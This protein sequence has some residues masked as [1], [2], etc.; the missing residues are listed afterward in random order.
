VALNTFERLAELLFAPGDELFDRILFLP[1]NHDHHAWEMGRETHYRRAVAAHHSEHGDLPAPDHVTG[2]DPRDAVPSLL[3]ETVVG[4][5]DQAHGVGESAASGDPANPATSANPE[6]SATPA[7]PV[8]SATSANP[9][10]PAE[11]PTR[12][13]KGEAIAGL[14]DQ[15]PILGVNTSADE[16]NRLAVKSEAVLL[17]H[18]D[19]TPGTGDMRLVINKA[20]AAGA[21]ELVFQSG[22]S[23]RALFG[24]S[25]DECFVIKLSAD[26]AAFEDA[27]A[28]QPEQ[29]ARAGAP[30]APPAHLLAEAPAAA[31]HEGAVIRL[32]DAPGGPA[33]AL[34][35]GTHWRPV[36]A[37]LL[38]ASRIEVVETLPEPAD[39]AVLYIVAEAA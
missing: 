32:L 8:T 22:W 21:A 28:L 11:A 7:N 24:L 34:S 13:R 31:D 9:A 33:L 39:P 29:A 1:G 10:N 2:L 36:G 19:V 26:G 25:G 20:A 5:V 15:A 12:E 27:L 14:D 30:V 16:A 38:G 18:D 35:D 37:A 17:S 23:A 6:T 3:L 4:H